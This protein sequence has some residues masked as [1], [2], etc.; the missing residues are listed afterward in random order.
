M[1]FASIQL[2]CGEGSVIFFQDVEIS[3]SMKTRYGESSV[4]ILH[5]Y[6]FKQKER[7]NNYCQIALEKMYKK[8]IAA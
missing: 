4:K 2:D 5:Q 3:V 8:I 7:L 1:I 6:F